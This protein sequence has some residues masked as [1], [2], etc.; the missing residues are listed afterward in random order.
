MACP[1]K[2]CLKSDIK[3]IRIIYENR[4]TKIAG[5]FYRATRY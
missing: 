3:Q 1:F 5:R 2:N 4:R